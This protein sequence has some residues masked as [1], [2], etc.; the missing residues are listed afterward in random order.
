MSKRAGGGS[1]DGLITSQ[2]SVGPEL[3]VEVIMVG[4]LT[5]W[6][7]VNSICGRHWYNDDSLLSRRAIRTSRY[8]S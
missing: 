3:K 4:G 7:F 6:R 5:T 1:S 2:S 8:E